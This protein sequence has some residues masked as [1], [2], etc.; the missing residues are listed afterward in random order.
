[1]AELGA[2]WV[3]I[4]SL[5]ED[6]ISII[7]VRDKEETTPAGEIR[8][9]KTAYFGWKRFQREIISEGEL[10]SQ[11]E[12]A[13]TAAIAMVCGAVSGNLEVIDIDVKNWLGIDARLFSDIKTIY[14]EIFEK[15]RIH[16]SPSG[17]FHIP[18][19]ISDGV[20]DGN[21]KLAYKSGEKGAA[22]ETRGEGGYILAPPSLG[23]KVV[24]QNTIPFLTFVER[25][26]LIS[27]CRSYNE[28]VKPVATVKVESKL[29]DYFDENPFQHFNNSDRGARILEELGWS[30]FKRTESFVWYTRPGKK[31]GVSASYIIA[32]KCFYSFTTT[33]DLEAEKTYDASSVLAILKFS[34]DK[35]QTYRFLVDNGFGKIKPEKE[36][37]AVKRI[38]KKGGEVPPN[39]SEGA[40]ELFKE[41]KVKISE[42]HPYGIFW[43]YDDDE[44]RVAISRDS[45]MAVAEKIGFRLYRGDLFLIEDKFLIKSSEREFQDILRDYIKEED[46]EEL[47]K[48]RNILEAFLQKSGK[49]TITRLPIIEDDV[50]LK[51][52]EK[53]CYKFYSNKYIEINADEVIE[54]DYSDLENYIFSSKIQQRDY[55]NG[56]GGKY[57]EYLSLATDWEKQKSHIKKCIGYLAHEFKDETTGYIIVLTEQC[58]DPRD[59]GGSGKN[60]FCNLLSHTTTYHSKNGSQVTFDE[61]FFQSWSGQRIMGISD[62]PKGFNFSFLKEPSTGTFILKKLFRDEV[63]IPV[64]D[65]PKFVIQTNYS[66][67]VSDGGLKRRIINI[68]FTDFFTKQGGIDVY[69]GCH[70]PKGWGSEDWAGFDTLIIESIQEWLASGRKLK[71]Q[72]LTNTGWTKQFEYT[73]G[74]TTC[75]IIMDNI[76]SWCMSGFVRA[77][78]VSDAIN[79]YCL[80]NN[81]SKIYTPTKQKVNAAVEFYCEKHNIRFEKGKVRKIPGPVGG[82]IQVKGYLF[83]QDTE[84]NNE[85]KA[86]INNNEDIKTGNWDNDDAPF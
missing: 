80:E 12:K 45:L 66:Y 18:Y 31:S 7:P 70:F 2:V 53:T 5:L 25:S 81:V 10:Y 79:K 61:K 37:A 86:K 71:N 20:A 50:I 82:L 27:L 14:P 11:M 72:E 23:Y 34:G 83:G 84:E 46:P 69:F 64:E 39:F 32:K 21:M 85:I 17:G 9:A 44:D 8:M 33:S 67:E 73:Y 13:N 78:E 77:D 62:V 30:E 76:E 57:L 55:K 75:G 16:K 60:V 74:A 26:S 49:F 15:L 51:D 40:K 54:H 3:Q 63:E 58:P 6:K 43:K 48:I 56:S 35:K 29:D 28:N 24:K 41:I 68:E 65:G 59:G 22:L 36:K 1:M 38:A 52:D 42:S 19:R 47:E 4:K